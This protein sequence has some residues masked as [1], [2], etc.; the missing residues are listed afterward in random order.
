M[1]RI[2]HLA[3]VALA[4]TT[5]IVV[6]S[7]AA[8]ALTNATSVEAGAPARNAVTVARHEARFHLEVIDDDWLPRM[9]ARARRRYA[10]PPP[11][12]AVP[13]PTSTPRPIAPPSPPAIPAP[14]PIGAFTA[15][16]RYTLELHNQARAAAGIPP[17][18]LDVRICDAA[19]RNAQ[20]M[21]TRG[22]VA[23]VSPTGKQPW[24]WMREAGVTYTAAAQNIGNDGAGVANPSAAVKRLFDMMMAETPPNDGHRVNILNGTYK[25]IGVGT[26]ASGSTLYWVV[27]FAN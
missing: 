8:I 1:L 19:T 10:T 16:Q 18:V 22:Y 13:V 12:P 6:G 20:D 27:D 24:D 4:A 2:R 3:R 7:V 25:R 15:E 9:L 11:A 5:L 14:T 23:H 17:L 21:A 26:A